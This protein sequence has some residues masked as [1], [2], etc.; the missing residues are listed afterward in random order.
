MLVPMII[1][2]NPA[3]EIKIWCVPGFGLK[4]YGLTDYYI[5]ARI[6]N[7]KEKQ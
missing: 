5:Q 1:G 2:Y 4:I 7:V 3:N 6:Y